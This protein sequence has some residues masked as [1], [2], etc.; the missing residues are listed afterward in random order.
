MNQRN[1]KL[2]RMLLMAIFAALAYVVMRFIHIKFVPSAPFLTYDPKDVIIVISGFILGPFSAFITSALV[3]IAEMFTASDTGW[4]G[5]LMN[6][7]SSV[8]LAC[9]ASYIYKKKHTMK[10][11]VISL[12][13]GVLAATVLMV[14]WNY[15]ITPIYQGWPREL[16]ANMLLPV[17]VPFNLLKGTINAALT[18]LIYK[19]LITALRKAHLLPELESDAKKHRINL[20]LLFSA[21][22]VLITCILIILIWNA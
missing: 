5:M 21:L 14:L 20:G 4:I 2:T 18:L 17:F 10:G 8:S 13:C 19:P 7:I 3:C 16:I 6:L 22:F 12:V 15:I 9:T 1:S 11:A